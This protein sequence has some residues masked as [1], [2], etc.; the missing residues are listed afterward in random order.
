MRIKAE[1]KERAIEM[2]T[3]I[4]LYIIEPG[5][6]VRWSLRKKKYR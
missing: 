4:Y 5:K 3:S 2:K 6:L 1:K